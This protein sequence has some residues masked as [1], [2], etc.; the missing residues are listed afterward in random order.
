MFMLFEFCSF[1]KCMTSFCSILITTCQGVDAWLS[2]PIPVH[3]RFLG[4]PYLYECQMKLKRRL[5]ACL[6]TLQPHVAFVDVVTFIHFGPTFI[7]YFCCPPVSRRGNP[8]L[9]KRYK[10]TMD[11]NLKASPHVQLVH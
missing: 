5:H 1:F 10:T 8:K 6:K 7:I 2:G 3:T 4:S 9:K 11:Q